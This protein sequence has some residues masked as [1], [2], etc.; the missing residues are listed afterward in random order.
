M[1]KIPCHSNN[2]QFL[3]TEVRANGT[4]FGRPVGS[5]KSRVPDEKRRAILAHHASGWK[6]SDIARAVQLARGTVY[7]VLK[8]AA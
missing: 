4:K 5:K 7:A 8:E 1:N 3:F 2:F 6:I